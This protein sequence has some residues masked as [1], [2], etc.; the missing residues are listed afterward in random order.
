[1]DSRLSNGGKPDCPL[2]RSLILL[3]F[4]KEK[5]NKLVYFSKQPQ[6][7]SKRSF[8]LAYKSI[9]LVRE[10]IAEGMGPSREQPCICLQKLQ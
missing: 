9:K 10:D 4:M 6:M 8:T 2:F 1:M 7:K 5:K 3:K